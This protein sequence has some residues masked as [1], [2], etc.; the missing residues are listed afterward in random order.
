VSLSSRSR[1]ELKFLLWVVEKDGDPFSVIREM[2][3][4]VYN[5]PVFSFSFHGS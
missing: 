1:L 5:S 2:S 4:A 3:A